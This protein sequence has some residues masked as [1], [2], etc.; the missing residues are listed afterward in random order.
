MAARVP[1]GRPYCR[2]MDDPDAV[3]LSWWTGL[4]PKDRTHYR[5]LVDRG[6]TTLQPAHAHDRAAAGL[7][8]AGWWIVGPESSAADNDRIHRLEV[9]LGGGRNYLMPDPVRLLVLTDLNRVPFTDDVAI[10]SR[11]RWHQRFWSR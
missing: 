6:K 2:L 11:P 4:S 1:G 5:R 10:P 9:L 7:P 3:V 8:P